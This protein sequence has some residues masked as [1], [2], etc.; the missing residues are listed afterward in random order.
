MYT[1]CCDCCASPQQDQ[2]DTEGNKGQNNPPFVCVRFPSENG[3]SEYEL[4]VAYHSI[5]KI[6]ELVERR[7]EFLLHM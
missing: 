6:E 2:P 5:K 7:Q 1:L 3:V 4:C